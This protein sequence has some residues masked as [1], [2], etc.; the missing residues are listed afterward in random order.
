MWL[1]Q[2][3]HFLAITLYRTDEYA[4]R[5]SKILAAR[6]GARTARLHAVAYLVLLVPVSLLRP[7]GRRARPYSSSRRCSAARC[8][9]LA[10]TAFVATPASA[11][12]AASSSAP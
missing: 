3:P 7:R 1:W 2:V 8:S 9:P 4:G 10:S 11:G 12:R 5:G 6:K